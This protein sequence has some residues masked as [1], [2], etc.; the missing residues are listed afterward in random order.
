MTANSSSSKLRDGVMRGF[1]PTDYAA[2]AVA[3]PPGLTS[4]AR[5]QQFLIEEN[6]DGQSP[7]SQTTNGAP[8]H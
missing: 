5:I 1:A 7:L 4:A 3:Q 8:L 2:G 6:P